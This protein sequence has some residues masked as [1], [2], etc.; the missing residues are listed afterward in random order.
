LHGKVRVL[1]RLHGVQVWNLRNIGVWRLGGVSAGVEHCRLYC[2]SDLLCQYWQYGEGGCWVEDPRYKQVQYPLTTNGGASTE[3]EFAKTAIAGEFVQHYCPSSVTRADFVG[4]LALNV[5]G[6]IA[7]GGLNIWR[8]VPYI[9]AS[10]LAFLLITCIAACSWDAERNAGKPQQRL[11]EVAATDEE[12]AFSHSESEDSEV[13]DHAS[14]ISPPRGEG[15]AV[16]RAYG[17]R[18]VSRCK[19][20]SGVGSEEPS[21]GR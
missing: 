10:L 19:T 17:E 9:I 15:L 3:T 7:G 13:A 16:W 20:R 14:L 21:T 2:Y 5:G 1:R 6:T 12:S 11:I 18:T 4:S 8:N